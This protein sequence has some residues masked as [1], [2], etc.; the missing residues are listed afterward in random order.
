[1]LP[2]TTDNASQQVS[3][4]DD[5]GQQCGRGTRASASVASV[6]AA[7]ADNYL[8]DDD[9]DRCRITTTMPPSPHLHSRQL[10]SANEYFSFNHPTSKSRTSISSNDAVFMTLSPSSPSHYFS[11]CSDE[12]EDSNHSPPPII[13]HSNHRSHSAASPNANTPRIGG[14][15]G[16]GADVGVGSERRRNNSAMETSLDKIDDYSYGAWWFLSSNS[17]SFGNTPNRKQLH[18]PSPPPTPPPLPGIDENENRMNNM[19]L[20]AED[21]TITTNATMSNYEEDMQSD[22]WMEQKISSTTA[23]ASATTNN[24]ITGGPG[25]VLPMAAENDD[26][27]KIMTFDPSCQPTHHSRNQPPPPTSHGMPMADKAKLNAT[28]SIASPPQTQVM[29]E[30]YSVEK[31]RHRIQNNSRTLNNNDF[32]ASFG[33]GSTLDGSDCTAGTYVPPPYNYQ[34]ATLP[35]SFSIGNNADEDDWDMA[36]AAKFDRRR[37]RL[38][39]HHV[40]SIEWTPPDSSYGAAIPACGWIPKRVRKSLEVVFFVLSVALLIFVLV[41]AGLELRSSGSSSSTTTTTST[42]GSSE[43]SQNDD[44]A[45]ENAGNNAGNMNGNGRNNYRLV[46]T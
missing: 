30:V 26:Q 5:D 43:Y 31:Q 40:A 21:V 16:G 19:M 15:G 28:L 44:L 37:Y 20:R 27:R 13:P 35:V 33:A 29:G 9:D 1:M 41:K 32:S 7:G 12:V 11:S 22:G 3:V 14:G 45:N 8:N 17:E 25:A 36:M 10:L 6:L 38:R 23:S 18:Q 34:A 4:E 42:S 2:H 39:R 46:R 24:T